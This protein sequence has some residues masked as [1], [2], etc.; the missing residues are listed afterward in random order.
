MFICRALYE[1]SGLRE[2]NYPNQD[3]GILLF[4]EIFNG[5]LGRFQAAGL[6]VTCVHTARNINREDNKRL[7]CQNSEMD[8]WAHCAQNPKR[9]GEQ[10]QKEWN[11]T[12]PILARKIFFGK[13]IL[14]SS[15]LKILNSDKWQNEK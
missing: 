14:F 5:N 2:C 6:Y 11:R 10:K 9:N 4:E 13:A 8:N 7:V 12:M 3:C 15:S 1:C